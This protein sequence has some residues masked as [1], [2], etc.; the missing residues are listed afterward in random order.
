MTEPDIVDTYPIFPES[1]EPTNPEECSHNV[2]AKVDGGYYGFVCRSCK[3]W[4]E[5]PSEFQRR[6]E[7]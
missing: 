3:R 5:D 4:G 6:D 7:G 2:L 1:R